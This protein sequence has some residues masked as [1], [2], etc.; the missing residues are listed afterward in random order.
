MEILRVRT[1]V[2]YLVDPSIYR[3]VHPP[4]YGA[5]MDP[6]VMG[7]CFVNEWHPRLPV[8]IKTGVATIEGKV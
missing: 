2:V 4:V 5:L 3:P 6:N 1:I 8:D 7:H